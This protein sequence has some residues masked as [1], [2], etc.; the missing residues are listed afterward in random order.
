MDRDS[1]RSCYSSSMSPSEVQLLQCDVNYPQPSQCG[2]SRQ[3]HA[4]LHVASC[5]PSD[6]ERYITRTRTDEETSLRLNLL[7]IYNMSNASSHRPTPADVPQLFCENFTRRFRARGHRA[8]FT[9][10]PAF[11]RSVRNSSERCRRSVVTMAEHTWMTKVLSWNP[12]Y[13]PSWLM[14]DASLMKFSMP[15]KTPRPVAEMRP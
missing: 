5:S 13:I 2:Q 7:I 1:W 9:V 15:W 10:H 8:A 4:H 14:Y 12:G 3:L 11:K 6:D